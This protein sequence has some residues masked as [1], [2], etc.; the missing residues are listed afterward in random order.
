MNPVTPADSVHNF[1][2]VTLELAEIAEITGIES[3]L[4]AMVFALVC[5]GQRV[6]QAWFMGPQAAGA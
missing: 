4:L 1:I 2:D 3:A 6:W 5:L